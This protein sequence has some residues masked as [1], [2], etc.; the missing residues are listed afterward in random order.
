M[1]FDNFSGSL[2]HTNSI[3]NAPYLLSAAFVKSLGNQTIL[4]AENERQVNEIVDFIS[5]IDS[6]FAVVKLPAWDCLPYDRVSPNSD[7]MAQRA[8]AL[9]NAVKL[10]NEKKTFLLVTTVSSFIHKL[11]PKE[12]FSSKDFIIKVGHALDID[13]LTSFL[14]ENGYH[15]V[16]T[17]REVGEFS[18]RGGIID[19]FPAGDDKPYRIDLFGDEIETIKIFD[20]ATQISLNKVDQLNFSVSS[21]L[22]LKN[23]TIE[24]FKYRYQELFGTKATKDPLYESIIS[25]RHFIGMEHWLPL[26]FDKLETIGD[27]FPGITIALGQ[28]TLASVKSH[29]DI[30]EEYYQSRLSFAGS[31]STEAE[32]AYRPVTPHS[33]YM[34]LDEYEALIN[35]NRSISYT[36]F[37]EPNSISIG[38]Q[39]IDSVLTDFLNL[40][41]SFIKLKSVLENLI[42]TKRKVIFLSMSIGSRDRIMHLLE[43]RGFHA[44]IRIESW[45][46]FEN[47]LT[48]YVAF[49]VCGIEH[50]LIYDRYVI[51]SE[52]DI[53]GE[54]LQRPVKKKKNAELYIKEA[55]SLNI[56]DIVVHEDHGIARFLSLEA[57]EAAGTFHDC[58]C[59]EYQGG[60]KLYLPVENLELISR[61]GNEDSAAILDKLG[62]AAWQSKKAKAKE[63]IKE[64]ANKLLEIAAARQLEKGEPIFAPAGVY[65]EFCSKFPYIETDDQER[66]IND[67]F[68]DLASGRPM[69]RLI[70][71][72][73]GF[74]KTEVAMRAAFAAINSGA[75][76]AIVVPTTLLARQHFI[77]FKARFKGFGARIEQLSRLVNAKE[78]DNTKIGLKSGQVNI[79]IGTH[80]LLAK[81]IQFAHLGLVVVDEEQH[82]GVAQKEKL[83]QLKSKVHVLTL[84]ATPIPRTLQMAL[85]G[86]RDLS[87]IATPPVDRLAV[88]TFVMPYDGV[89]IREA[90]MRE[91][92]R[93]GQV[94]Y[95][96]P[97]IK[98]LA[99]LY[100][101]LVKLVPEVSVVVAHGQMAPSQLENVMLDFYAGKYD[102]LLSTN[103]IESG[104]DIPSA[105][106]MIIHRSDLFGLSQLYQLRGRVGR[107]KQRA[108]TYL[109]YPHDF[110]IS[111]SSMKRLEIMHTL[112]SLG[113][114]FQLASHDMDIRGAGNLLGEEQSGHIKEVGVELYQQMLNEAILAA[115]ADT[116]IT[117]KQLEKW[118]PNINIGL[119]VLIPKSYVADLPV[120]LSLY[121]R[122]SSM[123]TQQDIDQFA[124]ELVDRF[125]PLPT[126]VKNLLIVVG[127]KKLCIESHISKIDAGQK[128][129]VI[130]FYKDKFKNPEKL[131]SYISQNSGAVKIRPDQKLVFTRV[132]NDNAA[133]IKGIQNILEVLANLNN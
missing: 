111:E 80:A 125:G 1:K 104:I 53:L 85:T 44:G 122:L 106:T 81:D 28:Q 50:G 89:V 56:G 100:D 129:A 75:Q 57:I 59:L 67:T 6:E 58:L 10:W 130:T 113:A 18:L 55:S 124:A 39:N 49:G 115:K 99:Y 48:Q 131:L 110:I 30:I 31:K 102:V 133:K 46:E 36:P 66:A 20:A 107:G 96:S 63:R 11:V 92:F 82:F 8:N 29:L 76:V 98:D 33:M 16:N 103:I 40:S 120:R 37:N 51:I 13:K 52:Q 101:R 35:A 12:H 114:G 84:S 94:F 118:S 47:L 64:I 74:G 77:N 65:D 34:N 3:C 24:K 61:Y 4:I 91:K 105:N 109:T 90:I 78:K 23:S 128:G 79:V 97:R 21:E 68:S 88:R 27:Y 2:N 41:D 45:Q 15:M 54:K 32:I 119:S 95:V 43:E 117:Q 112:D 87:I 25:G 60:D 73:V 71:G 132:W 22:I 83:K 9:S 72:D 17:V 121:K 70:C 126:E 42:T 108:Y 127:L 116:D 123:D 26:F 86:V 38:A 93:S 69:D 7:I 62:G 5:Y 19:V 14:V